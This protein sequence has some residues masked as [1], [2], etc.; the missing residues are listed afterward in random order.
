[1]SR[2]LF[3]LPAGRLKL[4]GKDPRAFAK[5][6][7]LRAEGISA[8]KT[9]DTTMVRAGSGLPTSPKI[10][11]AFLNPDSWP[12][13]ESSSGLPCPKSIQPRPQSTQTGRTAGHVPWMFRGGQP[14]LA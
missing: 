4:P 9:L 13:D 10:A 8:A 6:K 5:G 12:S 3:G 2:G 1:V 14:K 11:G 7:A